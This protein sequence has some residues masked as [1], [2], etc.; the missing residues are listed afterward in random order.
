MTRRKLRFDYF[1]MVAV[2]AVLVYIVVRG[3]S[4]WY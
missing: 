1:V 3:I 2:A 4:A